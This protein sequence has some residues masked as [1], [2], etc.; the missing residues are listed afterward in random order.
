MNVVVLRSAMF[1]LSTTTLVI[2][3]G[4]LTTG[5]CAFQSHNMSDWSARRQKRH[6]IF[7]NGGMRKLTVGVSLPVDLGDK[8]SWRQLNC[9]WNIQAQYSP[10]TTPLYWW[11]KWDGRSLVEARKQF[12]EYGTYEEDQSS[13]LVYLAIE[14][15]LDNRGKNGREC[16]LRAF[17]EN[18]QS[19]D[20]VN[21]VVSVMI[22]RVFR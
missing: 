10:P 9:G 18:A 1:S 19:Y 20:E 6:L 16:L 15:F 4:I 2:Y 12:D 5:I 3:I 17:C 7:N 22:K 11:N 21:T 14:K 13:R 8:H